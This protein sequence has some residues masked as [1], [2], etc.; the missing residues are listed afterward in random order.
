M[1]RPRPADVSPDV[2]EVPPD[3]GAERSGLPRI[4]ITLGDPWGI[5]PEV[6]AEALA[7]PRIR[8][9]LHPIVFGDAGVLA[10]AASLRGVRLPA[11]LEILEAL[12]LP[13][14]RHRFGRPPRTG[15]RYALAY[16]RQAVSAAREGQIEGLCTGPI[17]K[18]SVVRAGF[19]HPGHTEY[20]ADALGARSVLMLLAGPTLRVALATVHVPLR[21]VSKRLTVAG[22]M[23]NLRLLDQGLRRSFDIPR[24]RLAVCGL[25]PHAGE[26]GL[27]GREEIEVIAPAVRRAQRLGIRVEG[28]YPA[29]SL[30]ATAARHRRFDALLAMNHDQGLGP[31]KALDFERAV[32]VTLGLPLPRTSPD[33][34]VAYDLAGQGS[35][36]ATSMIEAL[37]LVASM[38][39]LARKRRPA[40]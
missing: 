14:N 22:L 23:G 7:E 10:Q 39:R 15:G 13:R 16:L 33:H 9:A 35:A 30:F 8:R 31:L 26:G 17:H 12:R 5:G 29:D 6:L 25:N 11:R 21:E 36:D 28:P 20:L 38:A 2:S 24:P 37:L 1:R 34:G 3:S 18:R 4:G 27:L 19:R 32:N 40:G